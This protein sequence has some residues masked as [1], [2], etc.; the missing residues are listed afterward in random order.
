MGFKRLEPGRPET[1]ALF[2]TSREALAQRISP[3][4]KEMVLEVVTAFA[5]DFIEGGG[6]R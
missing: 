2:R 1:D 3:G 4:D 5:A 6:K